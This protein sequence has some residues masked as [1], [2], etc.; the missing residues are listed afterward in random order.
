MNRKIQALMI[1]TA[2]LCLAGQAQADEPEFMKGLTISGGITLNLQNLQNSN[3]VK[4]P[5]DPDA[6]EENRKPSLGQYSV[7][8]GI[9]KVFDD[10][11]TAFLH[12]ETG[13]GDINPYLN[14]IASINRDADDSG[15]VA[16]TEAWLRHKFGGNFSMSIGVLDPTTAVDENAFANDETAQFLGSM[17]RNAANIAFP[18]NAFGVKGV[19]ETELADFAVQYI[20][21][22]DSKDVSRNGF[23][24]AQIGFKPNLIDGKEGNYRFYGWTDTNDNAKLDGTGDS[25]ENDYGAGISFDQEFTDN[26][27]GFARYSWSRG[28]IDNEIFSAHTWSAGLQGKFK[29]LGDEDVAAIAYGEIIP[30]KEYKDNVND[31]AKAEKHLE[32]YYSWNVND[33]LSISPDFQVV[34]NPLYNKEDTT[35]YISSIRMQISF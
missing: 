7:D 5:L 8:V 31:N 6:M 19:F 22:S 15:N 29:L 11:N 20:D 1:L 34:E 23:A 16:L 10:E 21:S 3:Y 17:F 25:K 12:F 32:F 14:S 35:A 24:S 4:D 9:E 27:G 2:G 13:K 18:D 28:D 30:S 26:L 33:Y